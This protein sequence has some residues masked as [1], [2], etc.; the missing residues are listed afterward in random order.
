MEKTEI[1][2]YAEL[3]LANNCIRITIPKELVEGL[4]LNAKDKVWCKIQKV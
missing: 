4:Q 1:E 2:F 3:I